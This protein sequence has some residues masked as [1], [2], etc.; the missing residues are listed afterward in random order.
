MIWLIV[1]RNY[2]IMQSSW[3]SAEQLAHLSNE[4]SDAFISPLPAFHIVRISGPDQLKFLQGQ[5][6]CDVT[7]LT[8]EHFLRGAHCDA[9]GKMWS[10]F[11]LCQAGDDI[12]QI[13]FR[14]ELQAS[15][16]QFKK[17]GVF[18]KISFTETLGEFAVFGIGGPNS[19]DLLAKLGLPCIESGASV[20][21]QDSFLLALAADHFLW[22]APSQTAQQVIQAHPEMLAA[23]TRWLAQHI[24]HGIPYLE[25]PLLAEYV[26][27][28]LNLQSLAAISFTKGCYMGQEMVARM[29]YLGKNKRAM[30]LLSASTDITPAAG[31]DIELQL[32]QNWRRSGVIVNAVNI[33]GKLAVLA[34]LPND[35]TPDNHLRLAE[36]PEVMFRIEPL[37]YTIE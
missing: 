25:Q 24:A 37:P 1:W 4:L 9:K 26:P 12:L 3:I 27:Q 14:D 34:V 36:T 28:Q 5:L 11:H 29:K 15:L 33:Q 22:I 17:Y 19:A 13:G 2:L 31:S 10:T 16:A 20:R 35:L 8:A 23:P 32:A 21:H 6:T 30:F 18:S 7:Q